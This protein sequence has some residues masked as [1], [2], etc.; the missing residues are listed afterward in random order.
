MTPL[1]PRAGAPHAKILGVGAYRPSRVVTNDEICERIDSSD[2]WIRERSG[3][4]TRHFAAP[5]K[6]SSKCP[7]AAS[8]KAHRC[9][10]DY[11]RRTSTPWWSA[12]VTHLTQ[13]PSAAAELA[14]P[15]RHQD[16]GRIRRQRRVCGL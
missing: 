7:A 13:T 5:T 15:P 16:A 4:S 1:A 3:I 12:T 8:E 11:Q 14:H 10:R 2:E 6:A 9:G